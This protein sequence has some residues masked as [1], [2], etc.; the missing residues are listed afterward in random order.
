MVF[1][2]RLQNQA[3]TVPST[4]AV[5]CSTPIGTIGR[6]SLTAN[7]G[8]RELFGHAVSEGSVI[9]T[10]PGPHPS[11]SSSARFTASLDGSEADADGVLGRGTSR[12][13]SNNLPRGTNVVQVGDEDGLIAYYPVR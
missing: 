11:S 3:V 9:S 5:N 8:R 10:N 6:P 1:E 7:T 2:T 12:A 4:T 13:P